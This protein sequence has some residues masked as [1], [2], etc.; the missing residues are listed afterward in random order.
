MFSSRLGALLIAMFAFTTLSSRAQ[1]LCENGLAAGV[2]PCSNVNL[3]SFMPTADIGGGNV[4]FN[5]IWGWTDPLDGKEYVMIGK[6]DGTSFID[7]S[8]PI[9]PVFLG[10][11]PTHSGNSIWR[12]VKVYGNYAF[13]VS[14]AGGHGMQ[15]FDLTR[16]RNVVSIPETF[17]EDAHY[18][19]FGN[20]HNIVINEEV[21]LAYAVGTN[22]F[23]GGMHIVDISNPL[24]PVIAGDFAADGYTHDA[25]VVTYNGPDVAYVG[26]QIAFNANE[27]TL[28]IVDVDDPTDTQQLGRVG[29]SNVSYAH[30]GWLTEDHTYFLLGDE[31]DE[32]NLG[33]PTRT[34]IWDVSDLNNPV[35]IGEFSSTEAAIDHNLYIK[36]NLIYQANYRA[37]LR[38]LDGSDVANANLSEI[39]YFDLYPS[40]NSNQFNGAW[41]N[42]PYFASGVVAVSHIEE[43]LFLLQPQFLSASVPQDSYCYEDDVVIDLSVITG[44]EGPVNLS[45]SEGLPAGATATFSANGV[46]AGDY[47]LTLSNLPDVTGDLSITIEGVGASDTYRSTVTFLVFDCANDVLGCT[48]PAATNYDPAATI[49]DGSCTYPCIDVTLSISTDCWG[50]EVSWTLTDAAGTVV[51]QM[52]GGTLGNQVTTTWDFC[53]QPGCYDWE[54]LDSFGDGLSGIASGCAVDGNYSVTDADGNILVEMAEANY[55]D[56]IVENFCV[57][58]PVDGCTD[59]TACNY[60]ANAV[61]DDGSCIL[62]DGCTDAAACNFDPAATCDD[63]SC[64]LPNGCTDDSACNFDPA[65]TCDDGSCILPNGCTDV[66]ACNYDMNATCDD[67]SCIATVTYYEDSDNDGFGGMNFVQLCAP[68]AGFVLDNTD[69]DDNDDSVYPNAPGTGEGIDNN[70][71]DVIDVD[72]Q[73]VTCLGDFDLDGQR[74]VADMLILLG[75]YA[76][77]EDCIGDMTG[78]DFVNAA[79]ILAFLNI[80]GI[81]CD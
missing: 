64:I 78:D 59:P 76:C 44:W 39:A 37:G 45:V 58:I 51:D 47:T 69:C 32:S 17:T 74:N 7:I 16:L 55:G 29:Y 13:V 77:V 73:L 30:Q 53:L 26:K 43:G 79:D 81:P 68:Q 46:G 48:D 42:Y 15:V 63:G 71:N 4:E 67:G 24:A 1:D 80:F 61:N 35:V 50:G 36:G 54:I 22:T 14:E 27:N 72:E 12:D 40:S 33:I 2:Y 3:L 31:L 57:S 62:P 75:D 18:A 8:D 9:N 34:V 70:C 49:E 28:T 23:S 52:A 65:A 19:G 60:D 10:E 11:L 6:S 56:G 5:D 20:A 25:Q 66:T 38:I 41:S 21:A